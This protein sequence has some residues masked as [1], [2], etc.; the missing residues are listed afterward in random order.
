MYEQSIAALKLLAYEQFTH[1]CVTIAVALEKMPICVT[2]AVALEKMLVCATI[3][4]NF[5]QF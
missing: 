1:I 5:S 2:I 3:G 4:E